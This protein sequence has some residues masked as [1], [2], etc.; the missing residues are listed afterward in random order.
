MTP[1]EVF[2]NGD[3]EDLLKFDQRS[4]SPVFDLLQSFCANNFRFLDTRYHFL[5][6]GGRN[7]GPGFHG[8]PHHSPFELQVYL[9]AVMVH[10][11]RKKEK[12]KSLQSPIS[13]TIFSLLFFSVGMI[14]DNSIRKVKSKSPIDIG[15]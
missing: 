5:H 2:L 14:E 6:C 1:V 3:I 15:R 4:A 10:L 8:L 12:R 13:T 9:Q 11:G 7:G